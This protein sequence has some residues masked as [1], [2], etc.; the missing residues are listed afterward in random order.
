MF[1]VCS[2]KLTNLRKSHKDTGQVP[3][4]NLN[5]SCNIKITDIHSKKKYNYSNKPFYKWVVKNGN[6]QNVKIIVFVIKLR[7]TVVILMVYNYYLNSS[8][9]LNY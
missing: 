6:N 1:F 7:K 2:T 4:L 5:Y 8:L 3:A 9:L